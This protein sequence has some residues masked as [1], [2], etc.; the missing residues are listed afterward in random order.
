MRPQH[1]A[2]FVS[3]RR[4]RA[5]RQL[6]ELPTTQTASFEIFQS[7]GTAR[8][9]LM[10][11][12]ALFLL[13][14]C[15]LRPV[16]KSVAKSTSSRSESVNSGHSTK[17]SSA[18]EVRVRQL[19]KRL[20]DTRRKMESLRDQNQVL[21]NKVK[22]LEVTG[23]GEIEAPAPLDAFPPH[24][25][26]R[27]SEAQ[28]RLATGAGLHRSVT[29]QP[30][31]AP[32]AVLM[33]PEVAHEGL[34]PEA[35]AAWA[36]FQAASQKREAAGV[37]NIL[38]ASE[39]GALDAG[40][41]ELYESVITAIRHKRLGDAERVVLMMERSFADSPELDNAYH[42]LALAWLDKGEVTRAESLWDTLLLKCPQGDKRAA[43]LLG[44]ALL[45]KNR[46]AEEGRSLFRKL[47]ASF[48]G[49]PEAYRAS[50]E[51][52]LIDQQFDSQFRSTGKR[53]AQAAEAP[54]SGVS[55][56]AQ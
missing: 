18:P 10:G 48:P 51:L 26:D 38:E 47:V 32:P 35:E 44:K 37:E 1:R 11:V 33:A 31:S 6:V 17:L 39:L 14:S 24:P 40:D 15:A 55:R 49:S 13:S 20:R 36:Q 4:R 12:L 19:E 53:A 27:G 22:S 8:S 45:A 16:Q 25:Q 42:Q 21:R 9:L 41:R 23:R 28:A 50:L 34:D 3:S 46:S 30:M 43:A 29:A 54:A 52:A 56:G 2:R 7:T 5:S